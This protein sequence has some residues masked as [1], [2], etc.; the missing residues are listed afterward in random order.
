MHKFLLIGAIILLILFI[1]HNS[2]I[3]NYVQSTQQTST[4]QSNTYYFRYKN[5]YLIIKNNMLTLCNNRAGELTSTDK[6][7]IE[8]LHIKKNIYIK[9]GDFYEFKY[10]NLFVCPI[11]KLIPN[12]SKLYYVPAPEISK[13]DPLYDDHYWIEYKNN[14]LSYNIKIKDT[15][16]KFYFVVGKD[17]NI[18]LY[19]NEDMASDFEK[20]SII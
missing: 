16:I 4:N 8:S 11:N 1:M 17:N 7:I 9:D 12:S 6:N 20:I 13:Y 14:K 18:Y 15:N 10:D 3:E 2:V 5:K 19:N